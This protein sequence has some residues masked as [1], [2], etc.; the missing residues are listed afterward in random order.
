MISIRFVRLLLLDLYPPEIDV[1][2]PRKLGVELLEVRPVVSRSFPFSASHASL[3]E[4]N[5]QMRHRGPPKNKTVDR[6]LK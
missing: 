4:A 3:Q 5:T 2:L 1:G 6:R